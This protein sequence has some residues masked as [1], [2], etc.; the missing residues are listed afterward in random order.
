MLT[1]VISHILV[2]ANV[3]IAYYYLEQWRRV[4]WP[5][6]SCSCLVFSNFQF[7]ISDHTPAPILELFRHFLY[8][9]HVKASTSAL[10]HSLSN[11]LSGLSIISNFKNKNLGKQILQ[12]HCTKQFADCSFWF[13]GLICP[14]WLFTKG[15]ELETAPHSVFSNER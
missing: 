9:C 10:F 14:P 4:W 8:S 6:E 7:Q 2:P 5:N 3:K 1:N 13:Y 15:S 12:L 11:S